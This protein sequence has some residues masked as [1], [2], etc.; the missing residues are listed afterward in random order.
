MFP[1]SS[2]SQMLEV[3]LLGAVCTAVAGGGGSPPLAFG[4]RGIHAACQ[5]GGS[6]CTLR[7]RGGDAAPGDWDESATNQ[8][9]NPDADFDDEDIRGARGAAWGGE[10][11][12]KHKQGPRAAPLPFIPDA[13]EQPP[14]E[15]Q[16]SG[17]QPGAQDEER[18][19][20]APAARW[21]T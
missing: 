1:S 19:R 20:S 4:P 13:D 17:N 10:E 11:S 18:A 21:S 12:S 3:L 15:P 8:L 14:G 9:P 2:K 5:P 16:G 6:I 7:L